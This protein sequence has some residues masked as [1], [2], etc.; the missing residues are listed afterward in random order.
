MY[1]V[2]V[3]LKKYSMKETLPWVKKLA[4]SVDPAVS[5]KSGAAHAIFSFPTEIKAKRFLFILEDF[6]CLLIKV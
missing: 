5:E 3:K 1:T 2:Q 4:R 6:Q